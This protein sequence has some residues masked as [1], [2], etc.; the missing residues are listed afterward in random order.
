[1]L[2]CLECQAWHAPPESCMPL[3]RQVGQPAAITSRGALSTRSPSRRWLALSS[4]DPLM[5]CPQAR[6]F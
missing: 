6:S 1:M 5:V 2:Q 4:A 3:G